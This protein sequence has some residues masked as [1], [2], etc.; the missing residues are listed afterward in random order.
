M[1]SN[2]KNFKPGPIYELLNT[3]VIALILAGLIRTVLFQPF[4]IPTGSMKPNLLV[5]DFLFVNKFSYGFSRYSCPF[6]MCPIVGR[7]FFS[8]PKRGDVVV[9]RHPRS[10]KDYIKR[11]IG[12]PGDKIK[13][14]DGVVF[15]NEEE[16]KQSKLPNFIEEK[17]EQGSMKSIP[18][19][20]N[21][22]V[23]MGSL[24]CIKYQST[25][26]L[27]EGLTYSILDLGQEM[28]DNTQD[29]IIGERQYFFLG[30][31]RDNS[32]DS[33]F[34]S[35]FG[36]VGLVPAKYLIGKASIVIFSSKGR[37]IFY[38]WTWRKD[39]FFKVIN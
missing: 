21:E 25:E 35:Q 6:S 8:E 36:G 14:E 7:I 31:N 18:Q 10:G 28:G 37:S 2:K 17:R 27:P 19:C 13:I 1:K 22:P 29:F 12:L 34:D 9:F 24:N 38:F 16:I 5:G 3:L 20:A 33:R 4:W 26:K 11:V 32:L 23:P 39:R 15:I 30:D